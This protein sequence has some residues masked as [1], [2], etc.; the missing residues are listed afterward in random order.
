MP[1]QRVHFCIIHELSR[2]LNFFVCGWNFPK[3]GGSGP[4]FSSGEL[5]LWLLLWY[6]AQTGSET[7]TTLAGVDNIWEHVWLHADNGNT[8][9]AAIIQGPNGS[10]WWLV[11]PTFPPNVSIPRLSTKP[12]GPQMDHF[13]TFPPDAE[14]WELFWRLILSNQE[15]PVD[16]E[17]CETLL[18][19]AR[20]QMSLTEDG[21]L[22]V[23]LHRY[24]PWPYV[25]LSRC[26]NESARN[27]PNLQHLR[28]TLNHTW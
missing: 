28:A 11:F 4:P 6:L 25:T 10:K 13:L 12:A 26:L 19:G 8:T 9:Q 22:K 16:A 3:L 2:C 20:L 1:L 23:P 14:I 24:R 27:V 15:F 17:Q 18:I 21:N 7:G 5:L